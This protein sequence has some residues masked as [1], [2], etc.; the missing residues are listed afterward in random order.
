VTRF[1]LT[2][3]LLLFPAFAQAQAQRVLLVEL[4]GR[5]AWA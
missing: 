4:E 1:L 3:G 5:G 2:A